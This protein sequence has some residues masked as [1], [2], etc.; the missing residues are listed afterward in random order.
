MWQAKIPYCII[1]LKVKIMEEYIF[2]GI[3]VVCSLV[4]WSIFLTLL[5]DFRKHLKLAKVTPVKVSCAGSAI[6]NAPYEIRV[7]SLSSM[8]FR[9]R[10]G[11]LVNSEEYDKY[12]VKGSS[13]M[14][15]GIQNNDL[16]LTKKISLDNLSFE[17]PHVFV[18]ERDDHVCRKVALENDM[19]EYKVRRA[20]AIVRMG[21]DNL[22]EYVQ[23]ILATEKFKELRNQHPEAFLSDEEMLEDLASVRLNKYKEHYPNC[24]NKSDENHVA[25][26][27]TTLKASKG[28]KVTFS[29]HPARTV[30][31]KVFYSYKICD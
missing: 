26:I 23:G 11:G 31:G 17:K 15:C 18:L 12:W 8:K 4:F 7:Q 28:N 3:I 21:E 24:E 25:V 14:L 19:A 22:M 2:W 1:Q 13:M 29:L 9:D 10:D 6:A 20:W 5:N 27:S 16:L 30:M